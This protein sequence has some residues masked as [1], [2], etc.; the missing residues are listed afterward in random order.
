MESIPKSW[1]SVDQGAVTELQ[2]GWDWR[3][4]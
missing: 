2:R 1:C 4:R 3:P